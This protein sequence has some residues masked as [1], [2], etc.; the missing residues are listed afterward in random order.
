MLIERNPVVYGHSTTAL[1][2]G[3]ARE[4]W[5]Q[6]TPSE[7]HAIVIVDEEND[8]GTPWDDVQKEWL[9][10]KVRN[11][12]GLDEQSTATSLVYGGGIGKADTA[13][14]LRSATVITFIGDCDDHPSGNKL[15]QGIRLSGHKGDPAPSPRY[16][17]ADVLAMQSMPATSLVLLLTCGS[18]VEGHDRLDEPTGLISALLCAG[19]SSVVGTMWR[20]RAQ[21]AARF[22]ALLRRHLGEDMSRPA[23][24]DL[25]LAFQRSVFELKGSGQ[26]ELPYHWASLALH[27]SWVM[28]RRCS[29]G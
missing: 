16:T 24:I 17:A 27:G 28:C 18:A 3:I 6:R 14:R 5:G 12:L 1:C 19:V 22:A 11:T 23:I 10:D 13:D 26:G 2:Q 20:I 15:L 9:Y 29:Y 8:D 7:P 21:T 25:T 4:L